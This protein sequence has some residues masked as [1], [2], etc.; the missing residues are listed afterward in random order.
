MLDLVKTNTK[1][2]EEDVTMPGRLA[3]PVRALYPVTSVIAQGNRDIEVDAGCGAGLGCN[4]RPALD[5]IGKALR[6]LGD[7]DSKNLLFD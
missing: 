2:L 1:S 3:D 4:N 5:V 6:E 7:G